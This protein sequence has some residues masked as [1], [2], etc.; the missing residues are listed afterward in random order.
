[1]RL[2]LFHLCQPFSLLIL[3]LIKPMGADGHSPSQYP[4]FV[5]IIPICQRVFFIGVPCVTSDTSDTAEW[6][7]KALGGVMRFIIACCD[8]QKP[9]A[10]I[11]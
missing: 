6:T 3:F 10:I 5:T 7:W 11:G 2:F 1:M 9:V 8:L 4:S